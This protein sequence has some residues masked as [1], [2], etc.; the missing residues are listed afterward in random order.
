MEKRLSMP[1]KA[2]I[3]GL[4]SYKKKR[5]VKRTSPKVKKQRQQYYKK[6]KTQI[7][8]DAKKWAKKHKSRIKKYR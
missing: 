7:K 2:K 8:K 5:K 4:K 1:K 6:H 3:V